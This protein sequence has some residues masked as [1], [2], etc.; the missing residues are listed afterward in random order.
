MRSVELVTVL[1][2]GFIGFVA[3]FGFVMVLVSSART[4]AFFARVLPG[5]RARSVGAMARRRG[6]RVA[7]RGKVTPVDTIA[8][9]YTG[10][11]GVYLRATVEAW[12]PS[13]TTLPSG[14]GWT[15]AGH[16]E[17]AAPFE[18]R[19]E[20][21]TILV[22]PEGGQFLARAR[23]QV[24]EERALTVTEAVIEADQEVVAIG[25]LADEE[26]FD[27]SMG[28]RGTT[29]RPVMSAGAKGLL[30]AQPRELARD[31]VH[32]VLVLAGGG[33]VTAVVLVG[34]MLFFGNRYPVVTMDL[35]GEIA[36][37]GW[38][39]AAGNPRAVSLW[40]GHVPA[41]AEVVGEAR[42]EIWVLGA[43]VGADELG[44]L[45]GPGAR[46]LAYSRAR[47][48]FWDRQ[49]NGLAPYRDES[50]RAFGIFEVITWTGT[51]FREPSVWE[52]ICSHDPWPCRSGAR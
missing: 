46:S 11:E 27:A 22:D 30:I 39:S 14:G 40:R 49:L 45:V 8:S 37:Q 12:R 52:Q 1:T 26:G 43:A 6:E 42:V 2:A 35:P 4:V 18:L 16:V 48:A 47:D 21:A 9:P 19:G 17:E 5:L 23:R 24:L 34:V 20:G 31:L 36:M 29:V 15:A 28:Y 7:V 50:R 10:R 33:A 51:A 41:G 38:S 32:R 44:W 13:S 25:K 3:L